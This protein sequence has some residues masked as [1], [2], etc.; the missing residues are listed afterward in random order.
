MPSQ[1]SS[2]ARIQTLVYQTLKPM[3]SAITVTE[4]LPSLLWNYLPDFT[5][6]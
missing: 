2:Q 6:R 4:P 3:I 5:M 1:V